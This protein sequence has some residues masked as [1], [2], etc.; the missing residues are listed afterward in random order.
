MDRPVDVLCPDDGAVDPVA[1]WNL[2]RIVVFQVYV[3]AGGGHQ[4]AVI[5]AREAVRSP[6][7]KGLSRPIGMPKGFIDLFDTFWRW[8]AILREDVK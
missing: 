7:D 5:G 3:S 2:R 4:P 1:V 6:D 8:D